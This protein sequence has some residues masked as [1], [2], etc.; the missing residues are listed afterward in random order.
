MNNK[1]KEVFK[2][3]NQLTWHDRDKHGQVYLKDNWED[4]CHETAIYCHENQCRVSD[5]TEKKFQENIAPLFVK[6]VLPRCP[7]RQ[8]IKLWNKAGCGTVHG[9]FRWMQTKQTVVSP[10][11]EGNFLAGRIARNRVYEIMDS[12]SKKD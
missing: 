9:Q 11:Q 10:S 8:R 12:L 1:R 3:E 2:N 6:R 5:I 4:L 7:N